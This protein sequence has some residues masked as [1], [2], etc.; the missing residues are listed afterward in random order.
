MITM[1]ALASGS[2]LWHAA[3]ALIVTAS[4]TLMEGWLLHLLSEACLELLQCT[5]GW[6]WPG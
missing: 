1:G 4:N 5:C 3:C 6:S 2:D